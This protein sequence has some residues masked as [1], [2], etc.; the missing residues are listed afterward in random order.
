[1]NK[2]ATKRFGWLV[3][4]LLLAFIVGCEPV[5]GLNLNDMLTKQLDVT[6]QEQSLTLELKVDV[7]E[8]L[9]ALEDE[10][11]TR[12]VDL[13]RSVKVEIAQA[14][15]DEKGSQWLTGTLTTSKGSLPFTLHSDSRTIRIDVEGAKRPFVLSLAELEETLG[16]GF[17]STG[18]LQQAL[19]ESVRGLVKSVAGYFVQGLPNPPSI[20]VD[21]TNETIHGETVGLS[22]VH[23][24]L[25]GEQLGQ[26]IPV[27]LEN[28]IGDIDGMT[29]VVA[30]V[31]R[32]I[33]ELPPELKEIFGADEIVGPETDIDLFAESL[34][35]T[36]LYPGLLEIKEDLDS[37]RESEEWAAIF[38]KGIKLKTDL[39]V[40]ESLYVRKSNFE[41][42]IV[43]AA[44]AEETSPVRS[45]TISASGENW[46]VNGAVDIPAVEVPR[47]ALTIQEL[48]SFDPY[49]VVGLFETDSVLY[50][51]LKNDF[52]I[53]DQSFQL[54]SEWGIPFYLD[55]EGTAFVPLRE[56][57]GEF[58]IRPSLEIP[59]DGQLEIRFYDRPTGKS[60]V[61]RKDSDQATVNGEAVKLT[62]PLV[63]DMNITYV[64]ADDLFGLL[65]AEYSVVD[66]EEYG[67][68]I[69][70][71]ARD[72]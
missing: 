20:T 68:M 43:P 58:N 66:L 25:D 64:A 18:E 32:W 19:A 52:Q 34:V 61:F 63:N 22:K 70:Q 72:L 38:D 2:K 48:D 16:A 67:E 39:Y 56:T 11:T 57:L 30:N 62:H 10:E 9:L 24:E 53:D 59:A 13:F 36:A 1:M 45:V 7:N 21:R 71:V 17:G 37:F 31:L 51:L 27:Y 65:G 26:L 3:C 47:N 23:A 42:I 50:D 49:R 6:H 40:D 60:I 29:E 12:G 5:G 35:E 41:A 69:M 28:L 14:K 4:A 54:S 55:E 8:E 44:F 46:N 15:T 33:S